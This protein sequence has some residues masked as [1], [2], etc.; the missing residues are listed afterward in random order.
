[1]SLGEIITIAILIVGF[2]VIGVIKKTPE[3]LLNLKLEDFKSDLQKEVERLRVSEENLH[4]RKIEKFSQF[5]E[6]L[7]IAMLSV[8]GNKNPVQT[9]TALEKAMNTFTKDLMFFAGEKTLKKFVEYR[10]YS[11]IVQVGGINEQAKYQF[12]IAELLLEM[13]KDLGYKNESI[14]VDD[15]MYIIVNDWDKHKD[16]YHERAKRAT[17]II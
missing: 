3:Y 16:D 8:K 12:I 7:N 5:T 11:Q 15:Y 6:M 10:R 9:A 1:M 13:R 2:I 14:S 4:I 17:K